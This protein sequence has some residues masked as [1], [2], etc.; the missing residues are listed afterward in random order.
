MKPKFTFNRSG[1]YYK[2]KLADEQGRQLFFEKHGVI[3]E[4]GPEY[5]R[6]L[7]ALPHHEILPNRLYLI[8]K[9][10]KSFDF[11]E[12][13]LYKERYRRLDEMYPNPSWTEYVKKL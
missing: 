11:G 13:D 5:S 12:K 2:R 10:Q 3:S 8:S 7:R 9:I 1:E 4:D 6:F